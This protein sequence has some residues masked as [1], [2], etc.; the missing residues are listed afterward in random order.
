LLSGKGLFLQ[1]AHGFD[2]QHQILIDQALDLDHGTGWENTLEVL[3]SQGSHPGELGDLLG[4]RRFLSL[5]AINPDFAV[6]IYCGFRN[7]AGTFVSRFWSWT[8]L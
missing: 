3:W 2:F 1:D 6:A 8:Y 4:S 5:L 7:L